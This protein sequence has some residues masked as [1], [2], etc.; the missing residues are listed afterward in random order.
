MKE[1]LTKRLFDFES[2][3]GSTPSIRTLRECM[4]VFMSD[5]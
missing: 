5:A 2:G 3:S 4:S 1:A